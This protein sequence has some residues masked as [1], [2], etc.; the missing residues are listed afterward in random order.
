M[1][2]NVGDV[3]FSRHTVVLQMMNVEPFT[4]GP[5]DVAVLHKT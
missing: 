3:F 4:V 5:T 2:K 1:A